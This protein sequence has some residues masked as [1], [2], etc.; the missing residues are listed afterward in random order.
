MIDL[1][2]LALLRC[3]IDP[4][5]WVPE[6]SPTGVHLILMWVW[7]PIHHPSVPLRYRGTGRGED[8]PATPPHEPHGPWMGEAA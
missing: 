5:L 3:R 7:K 8:W 6:L 4:W 1:F 2:Y